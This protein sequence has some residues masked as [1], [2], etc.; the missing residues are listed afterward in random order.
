MP[1]FSM[2]RVE[3]VPLKK[4]IDVDVILPG[5]LSYTIRAMALAAETAGRVKIV[6]ALKSDDTYAMFR[7][8]RMLGIR[9][10]ET[11]DSFVIGGDVRDVKEGSYEINIGI[12]GR[13]A[14]T[15][16]AFLCVVPGKK[17]L[18]CEEGFKERPV[19]DLVDGL[20]QLGAK[21]EYLER[22]GFLPVAINSSQLRSGKLK[23]RGEVSSQFVSAILMVAPLVG[24]IEIEVV[25]EQ[26]SKP[27]IDMTIEIM[28]VFGVKVENNNYRSYVVKGG[29]RYKNETYFVEPDAIAAS[30]F[31]SIAALTNSRVK[32]L[33]LSPNSAQGDVR[34]AD[35]L[36]KMGCEVRKDADGIE[37]GGA[38]KLR[39]LE[40]DM[41]DMPDTAQTL[42]VTAAFAQGKTV[43]TGLGNLKVKE[44]DRI[45]ASRKE[46]AK[47]GARVEAGE[48]SLVINGGG[49]VHG[50]IIDTYGDHR[51]AMAFAVAGTR[52]PGVVI[53]N[54]EVVSKSY[55]DFWKTF[56]NI[57]V[58]LIY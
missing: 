34:Y 31:W 15:L 44:T 33:H 38:V 40:V 17:I 8:F 18:T 51:M 48:D 37:V 53:N 28:G 50:A 9:C 47:M 20:L 52:I 30:Y 27:F 58:K 25:G 11:E 35:V 42:A 26:A 21:I 5:C 4:P 12:S 45:E 49:G 29:Q 41:N 32:V 10:E 56:E 19:G 55:P 54:P 43:I 2:E 16:L 57:G 46:L 14:R 22:P 13:A 23:L 7:A 6:N 1:L 36:G 24:N 3:I 39:G